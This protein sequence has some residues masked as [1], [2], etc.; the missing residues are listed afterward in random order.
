MKH[1]KIIKIYLI[2]LLISILIPGLSNGF[3]FAKESSQSN[4]T[5][6]CESKCITG[7]EIFKI[8]DDAANYTFFE[9]PDPNVHVYFRGDTHLFEELKGT[10]KNVKFSSYGEFEKLFNEK[11]EEI[12]KKEVKNAKSNF[13]PIYVEKYDFGG[14]SG[15]LVTPYHWFE[16]FLPCVKNICFDKY[17]YNDN[18]KDKNL[19]LEQVKVSINNI[20]FLLNLEDNTAT[21]LGRKNEDETK[22]IIPAFLKYNGTIYRVTEIAEEAF[23]HN[24]DLCEIIFEGHLNKIG[25]AAFDRTNLDFIDMHK[26][27]DQFGEDVFSH[28]TCFAEY[29]VPVGKASEYAKKIGKDLKVNLSRRICIGEDEMY[30]EDDDEYYPFIETDSGC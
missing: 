10:F 26:G 3:T 18:N 28:V 15:G 24:W 30:E 25:D 14:I 20:Y 22:L 4:F 8:M 13:K 27:V 6:A 5:E 21:V 12:T 16:I 9:S 23:N 29:I 17:F 2:L 19:D 7:E 11:F 1:N